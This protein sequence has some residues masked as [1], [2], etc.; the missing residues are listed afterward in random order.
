VPGGAPPVPGM[1]SRPQTG[2]LAPPVPPGS[3]G[4]SNSDGG[5][6]G[7]SSGPPQLAGILAGGMPKLRKVGGNVNT[8][9]D[10]HAPYLSDPE[11]VMRAPPVPPGSAPPRPTVA[12][13]RSNLRPSSVASFRGVANKPKPAPP[14]GKKPPLPPSSRKPSGSQPHSLPASA[15]PVP[16]SAAPRP[17]ERS[18][19]APPPVPNGA[20]LPSLAEQ[21][22]RNAFN[23]SAAAP[24]PPKHSQDDDYDPYNYSAPPTRLPP[25]PA[26]P[27]ARPLASAP[28]PRPLSS[29]PPPPPPSLPPSSGSSLPPPPPPPSAPRPPTAV[30]SPPRSMLDVGAGATPLAHALAAGNQSTATLTSNGNRSSSMTA[31]TTRT[32]SSFLAGS[33]AAAA[34]VLVH[35]SRWRFQD[36]GLF[37]A[38]RRFGGGTKKYRAGRVSSVPLDLRAFE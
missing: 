1:H 30:P 27:P 9:A 37:P 29:A 4:R 23:R 21:A 19:P 3:R 8:G 28:P 17:P 10:T 14:I 22:A 11:T 36:E 38:P 20:H 24:P 12:Q 25:P 33:P 7:S 31:S 5:D 15:P 34:P 18:T 6:G 2:G 32:N 16:P 26:A 13:L 35:D